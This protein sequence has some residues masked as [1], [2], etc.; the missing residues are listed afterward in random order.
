MTEIHA[1]LDAF[2]RSS[3]GYLGEFALK[4]SY[5]IDEIPMDAL[6]RPDDSQ[7]DA[8]P[9]ENG[10]HR[11][12]LKVFLGAV[13]GVG[14]TYAM[15]SEAREQ[16]DRGVDVVVGVVETRG[17]R[18]A[19]QQ[20]EG[21]EQL[22]PRSVET[23]PSYGPEFDLESA[24]VRQPR[25]IIIDDLAHTNAPGARH[26]KRWQDVADLL[27]LGIDVYTAVNIQHL[28]SL[29]DVVAQ[30]T[31][32]IVE[33]TVPDSFL[34]HADNIELVDIPRE[35]L[36][37]RLVEGRV[38]LPHDSDESQKA[39]Y[40]QG[41]L[42]ALRDLALRY[43]SE[44][45]EAEMQSY[46][47]R[48]AVQVPWPTTQRILVCISSN[49]MGSRLIR[50]A[51]RIAA[52]MRTDLSAVYVDT[53][54]K[55]Q[56]LG[57]RSDHA[58]EAMNLADRLGIEIATVIGDDVVGEILREAISRNATMIVVGKPLRHRLKNLLFGSVVDE[59]IRRSGNL[60]VY[61]ITGDEDS[62]DETPQV[63]LRVD[64]R[65]FIVRFGW[66]LGICALATLF[67][68]AIRPLFEPSSF[69]VIYLLGVTLA[70]SRLGSIEAT[71]AAFLSTLSYDF[72]F[73]EPTF[74]I[75]ILDLRQLLTFGLMLS[76][77]LFISSLTSRMRL[78]ALTANNRERRTATLYVLSREMAKS[79]SKTEIGA[80][81][82][83]KLSEIFNLDVGVLI[84]TDQ[85]G[86][87][88]IT[89]SNS[90][91]ELTE[92]GMIV[93][94][95]VL[96]HGQI[97]GVGTDTHAD[98]EGLYLPLHGSR[99]VVGVLALRVLQ[100]GVELDMDQMNLLETFSNQLALAMER[101][102]L[103]KESQEARIQIETEQLRNTLLSS[104]S[105][106]LRTPLTVIGGAASSLL[107]HPDAPEEKRIELTKTIQEEAD[108]LGR[109]VRNLLDITRLESG[110]VEV[111]WQWH[112]IEE[113]I[114]TALGRTELILKGRRVATEVAEDL[115]LIRA[116]GVLLEQVLVNLLENA[117]R[118]TPDFT[119]IQVRATATA[120]FLRV[121]IADEGPGIPIGDEER[122]FQKFVRGKDATRGTGFGLGLT[123]CRSILSLHHGRI[124]ARRRP[125]GGTM[126]VF[127][128]PVE[129][130]QPEVPVEA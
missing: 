95:W 45:V 100:G 83:N 73:V 53:L 71:I 10:K 88:P 122:I 105:H 130:N 124:W 87:R 117:V 115:P 34:R 126:F 123:I 70:A 28:E 51:Q 120:S 17:K 97:A 57:S 62:E 129:S 119:L 125:E 20:L 22:P 94:R 58:Q 41:S 67:C 74:K 21:L 64:E 23:D 111:N 26:L 5:N 109:F 118:H 99:G 85:R 50:T 27:D 114:G 75:T 15:L 3:T 35:E 63:K 106:D 29:K 98:V 30:I 69:I 108:R 44:C 36:E 11:G 113:L 90:G 127:E 55:N 52:S 92:A 33:E 72:L 89:P 80:A 46:R 121:E 25:L 6:K 32:V 78:Q 104:M 96:E 93:A 18:E 128:L 68:L 112:S 40:K 102:I 7:N 65:P 8:T 4:W 54:R 107:D 56:P 19:E 86:L 116:D 82:K 48:N 66:S 9:T 37:Q 110:T 24:I 60:D 1:A 79:R 81:A 43:T 42:I 84:I 47:T 2:I 16:R 38:D 91:F 12:K 39:L 31:G 14:K 49:K 61:V 103:A 77:G 13:S 59:L 76:V 101:T